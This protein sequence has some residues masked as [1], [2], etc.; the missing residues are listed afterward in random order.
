[1]SVANGNYTDELADHYKLHDQVTFECDP[2]FSVIGNSTAICGDEGWILPVCVPGESLH[3]NT[4][5]YKLKTKKAKSCLIVSNNFSDCP[6][7]RPSLHNGIE[8]GFINH[9]SWNQTAV[10]KC[11]TNFTLY[12]ATHNKIHCVL[13]EWKELG[14]CHG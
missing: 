6:D 14:L 10:Y 12:P 8:I 13:G 7:V 11:G 9:T 1:M 4:T 3:F 5:L 2:H